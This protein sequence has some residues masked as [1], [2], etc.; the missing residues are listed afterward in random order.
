MSAPSSSARVVSGGAG[1]QHACKVADELGI[2]TVLVHPLAGILSAYGIGL[3][4]VKAIREV[5]LV[6]PLHSGF[7]GELE[8]LEEEGRA[9]LAEQGIPAAEVTLVPRARLRFRGSDS[10]LTVECTEPDAM[11]AAFRKLWR[12]LDPSNS[13]KVAIEVFHNTKV[14]VNVNEFN[15]AF[16]CPAFIPWKQLPYSSN[17]D[18]YGPDP[19]SE[20]LESFYRLACSVI[21]FHLDN[22]LVRYFCLRCC[23]YT[24]TERWQQFEPSKNWDHGQ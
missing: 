3:A 6:R 10:M 11:D 12:C 18:F 8:A 17:R 21:P 13:G 2:E 9:A 24:P 14:L 23:N 1:G 16:G 7:S 20:T 15:T 4:P 19:F 5:S 22:R